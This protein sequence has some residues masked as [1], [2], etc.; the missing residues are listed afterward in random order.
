VLPLEDCAKDYEFEHTSIQTIE[1]LNDN[2]I[3]GPLLDRVAKQ[4]KETF[5]FFQIARRSFA[6]IH[7]RLSYGGSVA[8]DPLMA[9][10]DLRL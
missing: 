7:I 6:S 10:A 1:I 8:F 4:V 5:A 9:C 3:K 2:D